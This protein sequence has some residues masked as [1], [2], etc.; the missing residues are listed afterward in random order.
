M[1]F[2]QAAPDLA[3]ELCEE[4]AGSQVVSAQH[5]ARSQLGSAAS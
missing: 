2:R 1:V 3:P 5:L 4:P